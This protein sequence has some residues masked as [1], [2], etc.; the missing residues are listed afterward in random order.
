LEDYL[1]GEA[2]SP[3][4]EPEIYGMM[5]AGFGLMGFMVRRKKTT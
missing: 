2:Q 5:L 3:V 4:P 1:A